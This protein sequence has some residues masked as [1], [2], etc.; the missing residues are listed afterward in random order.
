[1]ATDP[2]RDADY[3]PSERAYREYPTEVYPYR[4]GIV[5]G[6]L[7]GLAMA[8]VAFLY[9]VISGRGIWFPVNLVGATVVRELQQATPEQLMQFSLAGTLA[10]LSL[11]LLIST[12]LG[13]LF[14]MSLPA[15][16]GPPV[17]WALVI[18]P[19]LF[20][21]A[22][23]VILPLINPA[24]VHQLDVLSFGAAHLVYGLVMGLWVARSAKVPSRPAPDAVWREGRRPPQR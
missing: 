6:L 10:A 19:A 23:V 3:L 13:L 14:T 18:G 1:M 22:F 11:H 8:L 9:G 7:G 20:L 4:A 21:A 17:V 15:L 2:G 12:F 24:M 16:P 5:G